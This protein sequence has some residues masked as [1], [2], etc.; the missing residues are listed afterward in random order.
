MSIIPIPSQFKTQLV[1]LSN[2]STILT[3]LEYNSNSI[4]DYF[5]SFM[6]F[7]YHKNT[8]FI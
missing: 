8:S 4:F 5:K 6:A 1:L 3:W 2:H 7:K